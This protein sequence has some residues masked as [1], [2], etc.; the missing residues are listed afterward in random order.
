MLDKT[1]AREIA[2]NYANE[3]QRLI[4]PQKVI[5]FGSYVN[6]NPHSDIDIAVIVGGLDDETWYFWTPTFVFTT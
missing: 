6:G 4:N 5:L 3:V 2:I 1:K